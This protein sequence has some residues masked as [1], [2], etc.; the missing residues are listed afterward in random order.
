MKNVYLLLVGSLLISLTG[1]K[2]SDSSGNG[3]GGGGGTTIVGGK[4]VPTGDGDGVTFLNNGTS[5]VFN[6]Y[7][8]N[9]KS[10]TV[11]GDF[12]NWTPTKMN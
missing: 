12:N 8:P 3:S 4:N 6:I 9:K 10:I 2:K 11:I 7:A 5:V 1:C